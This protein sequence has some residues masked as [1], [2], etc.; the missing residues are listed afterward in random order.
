[1][2]ISGVEGEEWCEMEIW[3]KDLGEGVCGGCGVKR[4]WDRGYET[5]SVHVCWRRCGVRVWGGIEGMR[6]RVYRCVGRGVGWGC[7]V[8]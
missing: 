4:E 7:G 1:M 6:R 3:V 5:K 8:G 2:G